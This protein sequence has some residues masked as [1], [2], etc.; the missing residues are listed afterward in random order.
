MLSLLTCPPTAGP[1][2][3]LERSFCSTT[4]IKTSVC[5]TLDFFEPRV[6]TIF[7]FLSTY[8]YIRFS[9]PHPFTLCLHFGFPQPREHDSK[10]VFGYLLSASN[11]LLS[12]DLYHCHHCYLPAMEIRS[13][14]LNDNQEMLNAFCSD[15]QVPKF[16]RG[17][18]KYSI[19]FLWRP[20]LLHIFGTFWSKKA[21]IR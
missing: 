11:E 1:V 21:K 12:P 9:W 10:D 6:W 15:S 2:C 4:V 5:G 14:M 7:F 3:L 13:N 16:E 18:S 19:Y 20:F 8:M 17:E